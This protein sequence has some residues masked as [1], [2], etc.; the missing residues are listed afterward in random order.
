MGECREDGAAAKA[1]GLMEVAAVYASNTQLVRCNNVLS[2]VEVVLV[3][4]PAF[5][6]PGASR[7][8]WEAHSPQDQ[9]TYV[10]KVIMSSPAPLLNS[11]T[12]ATSHQQP[13]KVPTHSGIQ[14]MYTIQS[15]TNMNSICDQIATGLQ[16]RG[17]YSRHAH[18]L[19][20][21]A[22]CTTVS[23]TASWQCRQGQ[24]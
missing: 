21:Y 18:T 17:I 16:Y 20:L 22:P 24:V 8:R 15:Q 5:D 1:A 2:Q 12:A 11:H 7:L 3:N 13:A 19:F 23:S 9:S 14:S 6:I 10:T 4:L